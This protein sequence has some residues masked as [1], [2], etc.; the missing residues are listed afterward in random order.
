MLAYT[1]AIVRDDR[2]RVLFQRR[3]DFGEAWWGLPG[4]A[5]EIGETFSECEQREV[6]EETGLHVEPHKLVGLFASP[7]WDVTYPNGDEVQ[8]FTVALDC[9]IVAGSL[10]AGGS[11]VVHQDFFALNDPALSIPPWYAAML[12]V[13]DQREAYF[14]PPIICSPENS[15]MQMIRQH[16]GT[17]RVLVMGASAV[18]FDDRGRVLL[19]LRGDNHVWGLPA[20]QMEL[21]ETPA[22]TAIR[23]A[24]EEMGIHIRPLQLIG[25]QTGPESM[26]SYPDGNQV[27][28]VAA[29]FRAEVIGGNLK[30]DGV[31]TLA[32]GWFDVNDLPPTLPRH[33][34]FVQLAIDYPE[35]GQ[36]R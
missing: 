23:E 8:Q 24:Q 10:Q 25:V 12:R 30:P 2:G 3:R 20:G 5:L 11:E 35:G 13:L 14:D 34:K 21:G 7:E 9:R 4:G 19:G 16:V 22:G 29:R 1:T 33:K 31:E 32:I 27:Q 15:Y 18:I 6:F 28:V 36:F 17:E 26:H